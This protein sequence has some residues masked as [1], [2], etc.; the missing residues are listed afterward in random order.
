M[1]KTKK[2]KPAPVVDPSQ[3]F[4][5]NQEKLKY[6]RKTKKN[7]ETKREINKKKTKKKE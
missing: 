1:A 6:P 3:I 2:A 4:A 5:E 7:K